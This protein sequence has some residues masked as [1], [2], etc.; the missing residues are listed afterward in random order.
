MP[1]T[2]SVE[3]TVY[4]YD[5]LS[6]R[7][8]ETAREEWNRFLWDCGSMQESMELIFDH[9]MEEAGWTN[10][11]DLS[12]SLYSQ[13]GYPE[14]SGTLAGF[15]H[16]GRTYT[17]V[18]DN[19]RGNMDVSILDDEDDPDGDYGSPNLAAY[20]ARVETAEEAARELVSDLSHKLFWAFRAEDEYQSSDE[21]VRESAEANGYEYDE[22][23]H[24]A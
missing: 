2:Y 21:S 18:T 24:L 20:T 7:A 3:R 11:G 13:G 17:V 12:Y 10:L 8:K 5:E 23:G 9:I 4:S 6:D 14:W 15:T 1:R 19:R 22:D 16:D